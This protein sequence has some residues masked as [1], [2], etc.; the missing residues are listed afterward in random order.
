MNVPVPDRVALAGIRVID[1]TTMI[2]GPYCT[3]CLAD[4]GAEVI[5]IE[6][7]AG[8]LVR[9]L[10]PVRDGHSTYFGTLNCGKKSVVLDLKD[11][12]DL[13]RAKHL[14][15]GSDVLVENFRPGV[16]DR[17]GLSYDEV[18]RL[19]PRL[20]YCAI[21]GFGG[22]KAGAGRPAY[23][24][25][26]H[27]KSGFD[28]AWMNYQDPP[29]RP[30]NEAL[31]LA[32]VL[33]GLYSFSAIMTSLFRRT[34]SGEGEKID[35]SLFESMLGVMPYEV[36]AAQIKNIKP[37]L[38]YPPVKTRDGYLMVSPVSPK[39]VTTLLDITGPPNWRKDE[40]FGTHAARLIHWADMMAAVE[41]WTSQLSTEEAEKRL[42]AAGVPASRY[43][44]VGEALEDESLQERKSL[45][46]VRD[47]AG[48]F[49]V[50][51]LPYK[52]SHTLINVGREVP[53]LGQHNAELLDE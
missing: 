22:G 13:E 31:F 52:M 5:K 11:S 4:S 49:L 33:A 40:R 12:K 26:I 34:R 42:L 15:A 24:Q 17:F 38:V 16:M 29:R 23:A 9:Q 27:A 8:D 36:Q 3:R 39:L 18:M 20:I 45:R 19:N 47:A 10:A 35:A 7:K 6:D 28:D 37:R 25:I 53:A 21:S 50:P 48:T 51:S 41:A 44:T 14:I 32:D 43:C 2:A 46:E 1:F 30:P